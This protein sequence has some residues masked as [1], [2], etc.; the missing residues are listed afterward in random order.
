MAS[1]ERISATRHAYSQPLY[2]E[3]WD[4]PRMTAPSHSSARDQTLSAKYQLWIRLLLLQA[5]SIPSRGRGRARCRK[6][7]S[8]ESGNHSEIQTHFC[9][10][11]S[12]A[13]P[14]A[15]LPAA[16]S[17]SRS[18]RAPSAPRRPAR[19]AHSIVERGAARR[20]LVLDRRLKMGEGRAAGVPWGEGLG[21]GDCGRRGA[22]SP[23]IS[24]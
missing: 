15:A 2:R 19:A 16:T 1:R 22:T 11:P 24:R 14:S 21:K 13:P 20:W 3:P 4:V 17:R 10:A 12:G 23:C 6:G 8:V 9:A 7:H 5:P 18:S